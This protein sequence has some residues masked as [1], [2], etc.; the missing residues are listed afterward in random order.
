MKD[1]LKKKFSNNKSVSFELYGDT[2]GII[3]DNE[4]AH[5]EILLRGAHLLT[6]NIQGGNPIVWNSDESEYDKNI[7]LHAGMPIVSPWFGNVADNSDEI[8]E[9]ITSCGMQKSHGFMRN[10]VWNI[11]SIE[12]I[13]EEETCVTMVYK[14]VTPKKDLLWNKSFD[15][16]IVFTI[17]KVLDIKMKITNTSE[18]KFAFAN[19]FH[20]SFAL[21]D[22][23]NVVI[24]SFDKISYIDTLDEWKE[25]TWEGNMKIDRGCDF[26]FLNPPKKQCIRDTDWNREIIITTHNNN[27]AIVWNQ[28]KE[29]SKNLSGFHKNDYKKML[30]IETGQ[31]FTDFRT[32]E[33]GKSFLMG[34]TILEQNFKF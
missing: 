15:V 5:A 23:E 9:S 14:H 2:V 18:D 24:Q 25:K 12:E 3:I 34:V 16:K 21:S 27:S 26:I 22:V 30:C 17:G 13:D 19:A 28:W 31:V 32:V 8:K 11:S 6:Y 29:K 7:T 33:V 10:V 20:T 4:V 1:K